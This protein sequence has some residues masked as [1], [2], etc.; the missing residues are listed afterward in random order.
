[1]KRTNL[2]CKAP[3]GVRELFVNYTNK[4]VLVTSLCLMPMAASADI[5]IDEANFPDANFREYVS[6]QYDKNQDGALDEGE[7]S[8]V[9]TMFI[10][11]GN[12]TSLTGIEYFTALQILYCT[13]TQMTVLDLSHCTALTTLECFDNASLATLDVSGCKALTSLNCNGNKITSLQL[14]E[15]TALTSLNCSWNA[16][17]SLDVSMNTE[18]QILYCGNN[19]LGQ[20]DVTS[21]KLLVNLS[22]SDNLLTELD[23]SQNTELTSLF[24]MGNELTSLDLSN[25]KKLVSVY[26]YSNHIGEEQMGALV[27]SLPVVQDGYLT[28]INSLDDREEN[29]MTAEL[30][31]SANDKG[32]SVIDKHGESPVTMNGSEPT[33]PDTPTIRL[34]YDVDHDTMEATVVGFHKNSITQGDLVIPDETEDGF[35]ITGIG[36][37]AFKDCTGITSISLSP[38]IRRIQAE[39]FYGCYGL[40][41]LTIPDGVTTI[42]EEAFGECTCLTTLT[43][44]SGLTTI[45]RKAFGP[46]LGITSL[47]VD[48]A[49]TVYDSRDNCNAII[50]TASNTLVVGCKSATIPEGVTAIGDGAFKGCIFFALQSLPNSLVSIG[51]EAFADCRNLSNV[52]IPDN[53]VSI[54]DGAFSGC[55]SMAY[56]T[57]GESVATIGNKAFSYCTN[58]A[59]VVIPDN[60]TSIGA[61]AFEGCHLH[62]LTIGKGV[63]SIGDRAFSDIES[64]TIVSQIEEPFEIIGMASEKSPFSAFIFQTA[65]L[66]V[67]AGTLEKYKATEGWKDFLNMEEMA[68][69]GI[70]SVTMDKENGGFY[71]LRGHRYDHPQHGVNIIRRNDGTTRKEFVR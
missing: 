62:T 66:L 28:A 22:C 65:T 69:E 27:N 36:Y 31:T 45:G 60:V 26:C 40:T 54:G 48:P 30:V 6:S 37:Q 53:V 23:V 57:I 49:N 51:N 34:L 41:S 59:D 10:F 19:Q 56:L 20:L 16:L 21:N 44:G 7:I 71:D 33:D 35:K 61:G 24:C 9:M 8:E 25:N 70:S 55:E 17:T 39:A 12:V 1:M 5:S 3:N 46:C 18:L 2:K 42:D 15:L 11:D 63:T 47:I 68:S 67:P 50:E 4:L 29:V 64:Y 14:S 13:G 43:I 32:W 52:V 38:N 58:L